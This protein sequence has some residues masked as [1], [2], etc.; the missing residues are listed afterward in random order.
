MDKQ[1]LKMVIELF[2][3]NGFQIIIKFHP[4]YIG[5]LHQEFMDN[6][7]IIINK[8]FS[9]SASELMHQEKPKF[10]ASWASTTLC[11]AL[12]LGIAPICLC[13]NREEEEVIFPFRQKTI[14]WQEDQEKLSKFISDTDENSLNK[15]IEKINAL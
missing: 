10:V 11:E 1:V 14:W 4:S 5:S 15:F 13:N 2:Q 9:A 6:K 12:Q 3:K 7:N 8:S